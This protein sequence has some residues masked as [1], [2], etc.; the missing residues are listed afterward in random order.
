MTGLLDRVLNWLADYIPN[1]IVVEKYDLGA[2]SYTAGSIGSSAKTVNPSIT[3]A[4]YKPITLAVGFVSTSVVRF[5]AFWNQNRT[6]AFV[7]FI[8][9]QTT[10]YSTT[11]HAYLWVTYVKDI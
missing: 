4:G 8:R 5:N 2:V 10:A 9:G 6:E 3:K 1:M 11:Y 7:Q